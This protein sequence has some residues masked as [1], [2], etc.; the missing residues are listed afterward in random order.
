MIQFQE[1]SRT[2]GRM[3]GWTDPISKDPSGYRWGSKNYC[4]EI[5]YI[6]LLLK[7]MNEILDPQIS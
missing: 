2:D 4:K 1:N 3:E 5:D 6:M 7:L